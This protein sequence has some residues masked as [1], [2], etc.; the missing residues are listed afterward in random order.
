MKIEKI[1]V[2]PIEVNCYIVVLNKKLYVIDPGGDAD[3]VISQ[4]KK[5]GKCLDSI[6]LTHGHI[7]HISAVKQVSEAFND[8]PVYLHKNDHDL[9]LSPNNCMMPFF[10]PITDPVKP[11]SI[12]DTQD[13]EILHTPGHSPGSVCFYFANDEVLFSGD[14]VFCES[15]G[16]TDLPGGDYNQIINSIKEKITTLPGNTKMYPGHGPTSSIENE[17][18]SNPFLK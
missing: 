10:P 16:R 15:I 1:L 2:G 7:D 8:A 11:V 17:K 13:F 4:I 9:Y 6:L 3:Q 14:T 12:I 5:E 18:K